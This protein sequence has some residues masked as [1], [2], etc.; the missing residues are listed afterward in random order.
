MAKQQTGLDKTA[1]EN[2]ELGKTFYLDRCILPDAPYIRCMGITGMP[3]VINLA[4]VSLVSQHE[5]DKTVVSMQGS[6]Y[7]LREQYND[8]LTA[9][10]YYA[11]TY[12][13]QAK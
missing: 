3:C 11:W 6:T 1:T 8:L 7:Y 4:D 12:L 10:L 2:L 5:Q 9:W 13:P